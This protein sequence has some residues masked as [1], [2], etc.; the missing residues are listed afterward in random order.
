MAPFDNWM[1]DLKDYLGRASGEYESVGGGVIESKINVGPGYRVHLADNRRES[2]ILFSGNKRTQKRDIKAAKGILGRSSSEGMTMGRS[3]PYKTGPQERLKDPTHAAAYLSAAKK[4]PVK[5]F[6]RSAGCRGIAQGVGHSGGGGDQS[7]NVDRTLSSRG[8][9][10]LATLDR[11]LGAVG[12]DQ[13]FR[14]RSRRQP[15]RNRAGVASIRI[16]A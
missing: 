8:N 10:T 7:R 11:I 16:K 14:V 15:P 2:L 13:E 6:A 1:N 5:C 3:R 9:P 4:N 12:V